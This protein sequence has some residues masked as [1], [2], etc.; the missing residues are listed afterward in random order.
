MTPLTVIILT[1]DEARHIAR[2]IASV[3]DVADRIVVV[4]SGSRDTTVQIATDL[5]AEVLQNGWV[6][7]AAQFN[8]ALDQIAGAPG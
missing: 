7:H 2:A 5:G 8:W 4:D 3:R 1:C 6:N